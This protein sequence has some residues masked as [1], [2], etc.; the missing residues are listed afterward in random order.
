[1]Y[2]SA[3]RYTCKRV[4]HVHTAHTH[5]CNKVNQ[6]AESPHTSALLPIA[7]VKIPDTHGEVLTGRHQS[8]ADRSETHQQYWTA[9][10]TEPVCAEPT[11]CVPH[12]HNA[13]AACRRNQCPSG[14]VV[15]IH[16]EAFR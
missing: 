4:L 2:E 11:L 6:M 1:M 14:I 7:L 9:V 12:M 16:C 15:Q 8:D 10:A 13:T 5:V 3:A